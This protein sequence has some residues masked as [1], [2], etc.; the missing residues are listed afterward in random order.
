MILAAKA[1]FDPSA[2]IEIWG[3][4]DGIKDRQFSCKFPRDFD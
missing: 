3:K 4:L 2:A 1:G